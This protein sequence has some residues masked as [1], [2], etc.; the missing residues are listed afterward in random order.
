MSTADGIGVVS[1]SFKSALTGIDTIFE[2]L[3]K[4]R[5]YRISD[6]STLK[7]LY[8][9]L[10]RLME[11]LE[12]MEL[13]IFAKSGEPRPALLA[14][15]KNLDVT[16]TGLVLARE[17]K[18]SVF[19]K[20][21]RH[22]ILRRKERLENRRA[23]ENALQALS[24]IHSKTLILRQIAETN[25]K[26]VLHEIKLRERLANIAESINLVLKVLVKFREVNAIA[27]R[28]HRE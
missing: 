25:D 20:M 19:K 11:F 2:L 18:H 3:K 5:S 27:R 16:V 9:E 26:K 22:G 12:L 14:L 15:L 13:K 23:Y 4:W 10:D 21:M 28:W 8:L 1:E 24:F 7:M 17:E 6:I